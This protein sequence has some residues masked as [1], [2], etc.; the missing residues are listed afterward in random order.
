MK[1][2][3]SACDA[4]QARNMESTINLF[5]SNSLFILLEIRI[6]RYYKVKL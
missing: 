2:K 1:S 6:P 5:K 3:V 4:L